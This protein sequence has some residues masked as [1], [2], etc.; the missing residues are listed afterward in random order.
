[1][2]QE[3]LYRTEAIVL[4]QMDYGEADRIL[5]LL[6]PGGKRSAIAKGVRRAT[7]RKAGHLGL[8]TRSNLL[9]ATG[10]NLDVITQA[11]AAESF[12][13]LHGDLM[14]F[15]YACYAA[16]LVERFAQEDDDD[17]GALFGL[18]LSLLRWLV[19]ESDLALG[20][21]HFE[22]RLLRAAGYAPELF[23]CLGCGKQIAAETNYFALE[24]GGLYCAACGPAQG[25]TRPVSVNA[26]KVL[27]Y[28]STHGLDDLRT[29][30]LLP[31]THAE[32]ETL[33]FDY[34]EQVVER[35][36][37]SATFLQ[38]LRQDLRRLAER[39]EEESSGGSHR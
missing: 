29:L 10:R 28:L 13:A 23:A 25:S 19:I 37:K 22:L 12:E 9:V 1:M 17:E 36:V 14:R 6:T 39:G 2:P 21:R 24:Q 20:V 18:L 16:E 7:S 11:E 33:L 34:V 5:T 4:R 38:R 15:T 26:Q 30:R 35:E 32:V 3:R 8:F 31:A 27:R